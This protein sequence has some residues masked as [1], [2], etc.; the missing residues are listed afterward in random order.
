MERKEKG[1]FFVVVHGRPLTLSAQISLD[2]VGNWVLP[3][4]GN[5]GAGHPLTRPGTFPSAPK[6]FCSTVCHC[7]FPEEEGQI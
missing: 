3:S 7:S 5:S 1:L 4:A 6:S 2:K